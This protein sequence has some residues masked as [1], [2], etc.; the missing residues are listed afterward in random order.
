M[1]P[2]SVCTVVNVVRVGKR[3]PSGYKQNTLKHFEQTSVLFSVIVNNGLRKSPFG[4]VLD[5]G[6]TLTFHH[7]RIKAKGLDLL[8]YVTSYYYCIYTAGVSHNMW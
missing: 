7:P 8:W 5:S 1:S 4:D 3:L 6:G 2:D